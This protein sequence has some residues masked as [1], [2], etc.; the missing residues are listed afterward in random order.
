MI[1]QNAGAVLLTAWALG[2]ILT[3]AV[4]RAENLAEWFGLDVETESA[5]TALNSS[6]CG[7]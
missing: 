3:A 7:A 1:G 4:I 2:Q 6:E 5:C